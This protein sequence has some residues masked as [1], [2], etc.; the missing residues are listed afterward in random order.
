MSGLPK[1]LPGLRQ[2]EVEWGLSERSIEQGYQCSE[3]RIGD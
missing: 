2:S 1:G 3:T